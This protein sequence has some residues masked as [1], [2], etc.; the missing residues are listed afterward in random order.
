MIGVKQLLQS[1]VEFPVEG[2]LAFYGIQRLDQG[3]QDYLMD[4]DFLVIHPFNH[5][6]D[7]VDKDVGQPIEPVIEEPSQDRNLFLEHPRVLR[8]LAR[9]LGFLSIR[10]VGVFPQHHDNLRRVHV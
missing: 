4:L 9:D 2:E 8:R 1:A 5:F 3:I 10:L 6:A 7:G